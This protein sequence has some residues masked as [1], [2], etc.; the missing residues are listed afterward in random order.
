[1]T[2]VK[3][4]NKNPMELNQDRFKDVEDGKVPFEIPPLQNSVT[5]ADSR[6]NYVSPYS[7]ATYTIGADPV[8][9]LPR[10]I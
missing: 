2:K 8:Q 10:K 6:T 3:I 9:H 1:M 5:W 7:G 4:V